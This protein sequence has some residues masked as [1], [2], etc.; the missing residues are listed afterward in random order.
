[1][2]CPQYH[3]KWGEKG[4]RGEK[5]DYEVIVYTYWGNT[6]K[7]R[8]LCTEVYGIRGKRGFGRKR[9][10]Y[11]RLLGYTVERKGGT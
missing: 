6:L 1:M 7:L 5:V 4:V 2:K 8:V 9:G 10:V 11:T 3:G